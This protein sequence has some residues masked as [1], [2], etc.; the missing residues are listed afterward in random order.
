MLSIGSSSR[1]GLSCERRNKKCC[2]GMVS[3]LRW[4]LFFCNDC[5]LFLVAVILWL[6]ITISVSLG[7]CSFSAHCRSLSMCCACIASTV[8]GTGAV[9]FFH[10][11]RLVVDFL[12][13]V[14]SCCLHCHSYSDAVFILLEQMTGY[15]RQRSLSVALI[16]F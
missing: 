10:L 5:W 6:V 1:V 12:F 9:T 15:G 8:T 4:L 3:I 2:A 16:C 14:Y 13:V 11:R 7:K